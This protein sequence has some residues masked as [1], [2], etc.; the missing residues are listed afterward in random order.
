MAMGFDRLSRGEPNT[1]DFVIKN[2]R[3]PHR[4]CEGRMFPPE[5]SWTRKQDRCQ[6]SLPR[7]HRLVSA[8]LCWIYLQLCIADRHIILCSES[9][10]RDREA[11]A[12][13]RCQSREGRLGAL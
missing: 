3:P 13:G 9:R 10:Q 1:S 8:V 12:Q 7:K 6:P 2:Y 4:E 11:R 5:Q